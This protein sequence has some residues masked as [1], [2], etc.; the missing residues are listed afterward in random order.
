MAALFKSGKYLS[1]VDGEHARIMTMLLSPVKENYIDVELD[2]DSYYMHVDCSNK[3]VC[4]NLDGEPTIKYELK[5]CTRLVDSTKENPL[6]R[7]DKRSLVSEKLLDAV[8][9]KVE[10]T[11]KELHQT[12]AE[13]DCDVLGIR[14]KIYKFHNGK[15]EAMKNKPLDSYGVEV[16]VQVR[17]LD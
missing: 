9:E 12:L 17:S 8:K 3:S 1:T 2:G 5:L 6:D 16:S 14:D 15:Y 10:T 4:V 7:T 13:S 11:V